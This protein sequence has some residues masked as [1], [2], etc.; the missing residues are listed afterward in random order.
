M[1]VLFVFTL[2]V[3]M[4]SFAPPN[5]ILNNKYNVRFLVGCLLLYV[6][7]IVGTFENPS[8][9][10]NIYVNQFVG[11]QDTS[12]FQALT[13]STKELLFTV[14]QWTMS[15]FTT[16]KAPFYIS[17]WIVISTSLLFALSRMFKPWQVLL[18]FFSYLNY[19]IFFNFVTNIV[20][21][22]FAI[23]M[24]L[25]A[26]CSLL[27]KKNNKW[28]YFSIILAPFFHMSSLPLSVLLLILKRINVSLKIVM[29]SWIAAAML[30]ATGYNQKIFGYLYIYVPYIRQYT[31]AG[32]L[33]RYVNGVNRLDFLMF[34]S[35]IL[36]IGLVIYKFW[37]HD[38]E[39]YLKLIKIYSLFNVYFLAMGF[40]AYSDRIAYYS[41]VLLPIIVWYP[42]LKEGKHRSVLIV[43][44]TS[45]FLGISVFNGSF[46][47]K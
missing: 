36:I 20:R 45:I 27:S 39:L 43:G 46:L 30:L 21:Q 25:I 31:N 34:S 3:F 32:L 40:I 14:F 9:D 12:L 18:I 8:P 2:W 7:Y 28:F 17:I 47:Y 35:F 16:E 44:V 24:I 29:F 33:N 13:T 42:I 37:L 4:I 11:Y 5:T 26:I 19:F 15:R 6:C 38:D 23:T 1:I 10:M 41:W 22:G